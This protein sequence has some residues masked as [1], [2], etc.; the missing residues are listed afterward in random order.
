MFINDKLLNTNLMFVFIYVYGNSMELPNNNTHNNEN[1]N[2]HQ[3]NILNNVERD[4]QSGTRDRSV[5]ER[6]R[7]NLNPRDRLFYALFMKIGQLYARLVPKKLRVLLE[8]IVLLKGLLLFSF[9]SYLH[10]SFGKVPMNCLNST[11]GSWPRD[12]ILR[13]QIQPEYNLEKQ[14]PRF[15]SP[16]QNLVLFHPCHNER[17]IS[18]ILCSSLSEHMESFYEYYDRQYDVKKQCYRMNLSDFMHQQDLYLWKN[19]QNFEYIFSDRR[20]NL[21]NGFKRGEIIKE[22]RLLAFYEKYLSPTGM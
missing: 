13:V 19:Y 12:G 4:L 11:V 8:I 5:G 14:I 2:Q 7:N 17:K 22:D 9:L 6:P 10:F 15:Y 1:D 3:Q 20:G 18:S 16:K 21:F